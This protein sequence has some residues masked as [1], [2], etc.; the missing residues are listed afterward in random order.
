MSPTGQ[1]EE[2]VFNQAQE[3]YPPSPWLH[4]LAQYKGTEDKNAH[5]PGVLLGV[6]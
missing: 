2:A 1:Q 4:S 6:V 3:R 5:P